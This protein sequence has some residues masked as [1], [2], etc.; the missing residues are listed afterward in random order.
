M[1][2]DITFEIP[3][4]PEAGAAAVHINGQLW[5]V[6]EIVS[7]NLKEQTTFTEGWECRAQ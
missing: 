4:I 3:V 1:V 6:S 2:T 7:Q 5:Q